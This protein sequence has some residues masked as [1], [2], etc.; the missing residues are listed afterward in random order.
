MNETVSK[1]RNTMSEETKKAEQIEQEA[2]ATELSD[3]DLDNVAGGTGFEYKK[4]PQDTIV[5][6]PVPVPSDTLKLPRP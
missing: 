1:R 3:Q 4:L 6:K 5:F 2:K